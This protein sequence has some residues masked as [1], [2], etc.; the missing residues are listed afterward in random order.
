TLAF[1]DLLLGSYPEVNNPAYR[2]KL[3][4]ESKDAAYLARAH[5][6]LLALLPEEVVAT[7]PSTQPREGDEA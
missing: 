2:I 7:V 1:P 5:A 4:L 6:H 3:T